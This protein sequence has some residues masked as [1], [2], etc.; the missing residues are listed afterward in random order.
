MKIASSSLDMTSSHASQQQYTLQESLRAWIGNRRPDFEGSQRQNQPNPRPDVTVNISDAGKTTQTNE[1]SAIQGSLD[2]VE[3]DP[4]L[5]LIQAMI[6]ALTGHEA[7]VFNASDL[8]VEH[9]ASA[10]Q[11][12]A[13]STTSQAQPQQAAGFGIEYERHESY[14]ESEQT[15]LQ[16]SG[17]VRTADGKEI[18]FSLALS[19]SRSYH[20][21][22]STSLRLGDARQKQDPLVVNF[23]GSAAQLS[24]QRFKFDLNADGQNEDINFATNGSGFLALDRNGDGRIN[25]GSELFGASSGNGFAELAQLDSDHNGWIDENDAAFGQLRILTKDASGQDQLS[26]LK[27]NNIGALGLESI[28]TPFALKDS[29]NNLQGQITQSAVYLKEDGAIG[30]VQQIDLTV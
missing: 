9:P 27:Q 5:R 24:S 14:S 28:A 11:S 13:Q 12:P 26:S 15:Q 22:S 18:T 4:I 7:H 19:M 29:S 8:Q 6:F 25:N 10:V 17:T 1:A 16:A 21:E 3:N 2:D 23:S 30:T 20:E